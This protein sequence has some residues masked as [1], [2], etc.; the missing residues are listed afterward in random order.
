MKITRKI[1]INISFFY[2]LLVSAICF[3]ISSPLLIEISTRI[4]VDI[5]HLGSIFSFYFGGFIFGSYL[6]SFLVK[7]FTRKKIMTF[8]YFLL[9]TGI[10]SL[11]FLF[12]YT[13]LVVILFLVGLCSGFIEPQISI[14]IIEINKK[15]EGLFITLSQVFYGIG[16]FVGPFIT[17]LVSIAGFN[18]KYS[19]I[20]A[21]ILCFTNI[22]FFLF[23]DFSGIEIKELKKEINI[24]EIIK[25]KDRTLFLLL[26]FS[27]IFYYCAITGLSTWIPTFLRLNKSFT[28]IIAAHILSFFWIATIAGRIIIG[29]LIKKIEIIKILLVIIILSIIS[30][31]GGIY[32]K[33]N[34]LVIFSFIFCGLSISGIWPLIITKGGLHY[35]DRINLIVSALTLFGGLGGLLAPALIGFI[36]L[37]TN[38][39]V[40]M[41]II[42]IFL[43]I[44]LIFVLSIF[45]INKRNKVESQ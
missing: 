4:N 30:V 35:P 36:F 5:R 12:N 34:L 3:T 7:Y 29:S 19:Y 33:N 9:T 43:I 21:S 18:W 14:L 42:Y 39:F 1:F 38:L 22:I 2:T 23:I 11:Y 26:V 44:I 27:M 24:S 25:L 20:V 41:N 32:F 45:L 16:A 31:I 28:N 17:V 15:N 40:A 13:F 37:K 8:F 6:S 10:F